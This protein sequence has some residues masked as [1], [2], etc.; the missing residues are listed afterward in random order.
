[1]KKFV[2]S[3]QRLNNVDRKGLVSSGPFEELWKGFYQTSP[4]FGSWP[5]YDHRYHFGFDEF[6]LELK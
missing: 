6:D 2:F 3:K 1:M 4:D 5:F